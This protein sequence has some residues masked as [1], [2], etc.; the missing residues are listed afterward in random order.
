MIFS[1]IKQALGF[2]RCTHYYSAA[3]PLSSDI[4]KYFYSIDIPIYECFGMSEVSGAHTL[5]VEGATN[6][7]TIG[8]TLP[9]MKTKLANPEDG[10][11]EIC[12]YGRH[13]FM[14]YLKDEEKTNETL[15][16]EGW[17]HTGDLGHVDDK[18]FVYITGRLKELIITAGGENIPPVQ[19]EQ[20]VKSELSHISNAFLIGD[21]KKFL[22][23]LITL[24]T[25][26]DLDTGK[27]IFIL[28]IGANRIYCTI[29]QYYHIEPIHNHD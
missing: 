27:H 28:K 15:D 18:E 4:K 17:L 2:N 10:Q 26:V 12:I 11:G 5:C 29:F 9:G 25:N 24:K 6:L 22:S 16:S 23:I 3:A 21:Q 7:D 14:G 13:V 8:M 20:Q 1:K 19:I